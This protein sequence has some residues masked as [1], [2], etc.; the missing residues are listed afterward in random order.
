ME[1]VAFGN[2]STKGQICIPV[3]LRK[4]WKEGERFVF[5]LDKTK[6]KLLIQRAN[7]FSKRFEDDI[8]QAIRVEESWKRYDKGEFQTM[9]FDDFIREIKKW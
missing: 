5:F 7:N 3:E 4:H 6:S 9:E 1:A 8:K 2:L